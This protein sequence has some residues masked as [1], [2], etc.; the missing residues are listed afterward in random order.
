[1]KAHTEI[2]QTAEHLNYSVKRPT[3]KQLFSVQ[4]YLM[5]VL[6][7][8]HLVVGILLFLIMTFLESVNLHYL[9]IICNAQNVSFKCLL[10]FCVYTNI[11]HIVRLNIMR[12][13]DG[14]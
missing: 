10:F 13:T 8:I 5:H 4:K 9:L 12:L 1:M 2:A 7:A 6:L 11:Y 3:T 14:E